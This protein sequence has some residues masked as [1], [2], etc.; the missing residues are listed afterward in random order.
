L[1]DVIVPMCQSPKVTEVV[2][3]AKTVP[4]N[5][6]YMQAD[7]KSFEPE[8]VSKAAWPALFILVGIIAYF[9]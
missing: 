6:N 4:A 5:D 9:I 8:S 2:L 3:R 1:E 7:M